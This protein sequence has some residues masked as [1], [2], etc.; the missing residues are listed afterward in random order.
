[1]RRT[2]LHAA[3]IAVL[4]V[5]LSDVPRGSLQ[6]RVAPIIEMR[7]L[8]SLFAMDAQCTRLRIMN[9]DAKTVVRLLCEVDTI[10][11]APDAPPFAS[12]LWL[13]PVRGYKKEARRILPVVNQSGVD[14]FN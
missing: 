4:P 11:A 3:T 9:N 7:A 12:C 13:K 5:F 10:A 1:M 2:F 14:A 6:E 8:L